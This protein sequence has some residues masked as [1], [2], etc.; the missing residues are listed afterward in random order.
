MGKNKNLMLVIL[1]LITFFCTFSIYAQEELKRAK[2]L[3][4]SS[5]YDFL[6]INLGEKDGIEIGNLYKVT[7]YGEDIG[8]IKVLRARSSISACDMSNINKG[9]IL[10]PEEYIYLMPI[11]MLAE[12]E[13]DKPEVREPIPEEIK[14]AVRPPVAIFEEKKVPPSR[15]TEPVSLPEVQVEEKLPVVEIERRPTF[16]SRLKHLFKP[17]ERRPEYLERERLQPVSLNVDI[18]AD[19]EIIMFFLDTELKERDFIIT[20]SSRFR[21]LITA[22]KLM[23]LSFLEGMWADFSGSVDHKIIYLVSIEE[24]KN[25]SRLSLELNATFK[26]RGEIFNLELTPPSKVYEEAREIMQIVKQRAEKHVSSR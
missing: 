10:Q 12:V 13:P 23:P 11:T 22:E 3:S 17:R 15:I 14:V 2:I 7:R 21:G 6:V 9:V 26:R 4:V 16:F 25:I 19:R 1:I 20:S 18:F 8:N 5:V 24:G